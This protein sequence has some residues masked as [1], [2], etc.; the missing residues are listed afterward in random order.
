V[1]LEFKLNQIRNYL[2]TRIDAKNLN[3]QKSPKDLA[4]EICP[5]NFGRAVVLT[6]FIEL[7]TSKLTKDKSINVA[8][9]GGNLDEP[10]VRALFAL[11]FEPKV[12]ILGIENDNYYF[13]L[14]LPQDFSFTKIDQFDLILCSQV[15]EHIWNH[16]AAFRNLLKLASNKSFLWVGCPTSNRP[17][18]SPSYY[19]AGFTSEYLA[20]NLENL[21][22]EILDQG[23]FGSKRNYQLTHL[24]PTWL[25]VRGHMFPPLFAFEGR[26]MLVRLYYSIRFLPTTLWSLCS[27]KKISEGDR[28]ATES[29]VL[30]E[31]NN[32]E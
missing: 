22:F 17:H 5:G 19:S 27:S 16:E 18:G 29:W 30:A 9:V 4:F 3:A 6:K 1:A 10:E 25:S 21:G 11:G 12:T 24:L 23:Q 32:S 14:N 31:K 15:F 26:R 28:F 8:I 20:L 2:G 13:D 7:I